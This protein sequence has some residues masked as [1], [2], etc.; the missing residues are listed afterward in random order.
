MSPVVFL[1]AALNAHA[2]QILSLFVDVQWVFCT[3]INFIQHYVINKQ[4]L[5]MTWVVF[6]LPSA[7]IALLGIGAEIPV[8]YAVLCMANSAANVYGR[9]ILLVLQFSMS[10]YHKDNQHWK[11]ARVSTTLP[12]TSAHLLTWPPIYFERKYYW[13]DRHFNWFW[14]DAL[15]VIQRVQPAVP[16][17]PCINSMSI[18]LPGKIWHSKGTL[19][20]YWF[21]LLGI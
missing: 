10:L 19:V 9:N 8:H 5:R 21:W 15:A 11:I 4:R 7:C 13:A 16:S 6:Y 1:S 2:M 18:C 14:P 12:F 20:L 3:Q 17:R